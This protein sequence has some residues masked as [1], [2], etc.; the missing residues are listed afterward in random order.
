MFCIFAHCLWIKGSDLKKLKQPK[1]LLY[2][3]KMAAA[4]N[5][6]WVFYIAIGL[7]NKLNFN[8]WVLDKGWA[9][10]FWLKLL[11]EPAIQVLLL[12]L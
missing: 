5:V 12:W 10:Q 9:I 11:F 1:D 7:I 8:N 6:S 3:F 2:T 4:K